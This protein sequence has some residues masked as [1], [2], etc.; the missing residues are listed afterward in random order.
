M[1]EKSRDKNEVDGT[2][3]EEGVPHQVHCGIAWNAQTVRSP[4]DMG[5]H[6]VY[7]GECTEIMHID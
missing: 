1:K 5:E 2:V 6:D 3:V 7:N 4:E